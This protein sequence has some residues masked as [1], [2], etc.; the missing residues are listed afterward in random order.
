[1]IHI[2]E[3]LLCRFFGKIFLDLPLKGVLEIHNLVLFLVLFFVLFFISLVLLFLLNKRNHHC[4][5][6]SP[7]HFF[8]L[9]IP[10]RFFSVICLDTTFL[11]L[12]D[13]LE[14]GADQ[15]GD[16]APPANAPPVLPDQAGDLA[17][18]AADA[19]P[20]LPEDPAGDPAQPADAPLAPAVQVPAILNP[21][22]VPS[23]PS[24]LDPGR[25]PEARVREGTEA[26]VTGA[27]KG[28]C[29]SFVECLCSTWCD[30]F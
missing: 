21:P 12:D 13:N 11:L 26:A 14:N 6:H 8:V 17:Q 2:L 18:P 16:Q 27:V 20:V 3:R 7:K 9:Y 15:A 30:S 1:M 23:I 28:C 22:R 29:S 24:S 25:T 5:K 10:F 4:E 19:P